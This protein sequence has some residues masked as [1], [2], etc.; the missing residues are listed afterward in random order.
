MTELPDWALI[1]PDEASIKKQTDE[2][3]AFLPRKDPE[4][5]MNHLI[6]QD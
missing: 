4:S 6:I 2:M 5:L 3:R 1:F